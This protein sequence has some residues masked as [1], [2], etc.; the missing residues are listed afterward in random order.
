MDSSLVVE[1]GRVHARP[2]DPHAR[3]T[4]R[5]FAHL[6]DAPAPVLS[7]SHEI[8]EGAPRVGHDNLVAVDHQAVI[9]RRLAERAVAR[10][11]HVA[12]VQEDARA[13]RAGHLGGPVGRASVDDHD[14]VDLSPQALERGAEDAGLV[15]HDET[16]AQTH[17]RAPGAR[18]LREA[19]SGGVLPK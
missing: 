6:E 8:A 4:A 3:G 11:A 7:S 19:T 15:L 1:L 10:R 2:G 18:L 5:R 12:F 17:G 14:L 9:A 16:G 13:G